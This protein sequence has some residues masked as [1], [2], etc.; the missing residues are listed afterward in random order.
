MN[1]MLFGDEGEELT[2]DPLPF[3]EIPQLDMMVYDDEGTE[4]FH[5]ALPHEAIP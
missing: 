2:H 5:D 1:I 3:E 4:E